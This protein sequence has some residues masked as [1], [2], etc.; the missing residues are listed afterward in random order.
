MKR[1]LFLTMAFVCLQSGLQP[2]YAS[3]D[4]DVPKAV[5]PGEFNTLRQLV[6][7]WVGKSDMGG[8]KQQ[9][10]KVIYKLTSGGTAITETLMAGTPQEME[11]VYYRE[12]DSLGMTHYCALGNHPQMTLKK[13]R[14][15]KVLAFEMNGVRGIQSIDEPHMHGVTLT[16][17]DE[18]TL[19][20][21]WVHYQDGKALQTVTFVLH[22]Q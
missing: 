6:G 4:H 12:G 7:T 14:D 15:E 11:S 21:D 19:Q 1:S 2:A 18:D 10:M 13:S 16:M 5:M 20:Q 3:A 22:R 9:T 8:G 17:V